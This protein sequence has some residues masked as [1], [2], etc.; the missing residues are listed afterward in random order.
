LSLPHRETN[1]YNPAMIVIRGE[2]HSSKNSRRV[3]RVGHRTIVA[4][5]KQAKA[6]EEILYIQLRAQ[7]DEWDKMIDGV[8]EPINVV[9]HFVR[10]TRRRWDFVNLV[11]GVAD[12]MVKAGYM[13]DDDVNHFIPHYGGHTVDKNNPG[14]EFWIKK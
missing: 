5:S 14:V 6:D 9:F 12:A 11:Q 3:L 2:I 8:E 7:I 1:C 10:A 13:E 4:K